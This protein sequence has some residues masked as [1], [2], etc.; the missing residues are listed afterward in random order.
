MSHALKILLRV[1]QNRLQCNCE[2]LISDSLGSVTRAGY[3]KDAS[4]C[5]MNVLLQKCTE[6][7]KPLLLC[8]IDFE[9]N[10]FNPKRN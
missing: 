10:F 7:Q 6:F 8:F 2:S 5:M 1:I 3:Q 4:Y 9:D